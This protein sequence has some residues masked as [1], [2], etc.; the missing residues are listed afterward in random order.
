ME[1]ARKVAGALRG[2]KRKRLASPL[3]SWP[4]PPAPPASALMKTL[5]PFLLASWVCV[6]AIAA[7]KLNVLFIATDDWRPE[8][9]CYGAKGMVTPN[10]DKFAASA[11]RFERAYCQFPLCNPSRTSMLTGRY[12]T[13]TGVLNNDGVFHQMHPDWV[14]LPQHFKD[15]G[16]F[17]A[18]TGKIFHGGLDDKKAW[19]EVRRAVVPAGRGIKPPEGWKPTTP[20]PGA[21]R[22]RQDPR[23]SDR[24]VT[25][26]GDGEDHADY[27]VAKHG[28]ALLEENKD[29]PFFIA[30]GFT[31]PHSPPTAPQRFFDLHDPAKIELPPDFATRPAAP[32]GF[33]KASIPERSGDLFINRD[34]SPD[35]ARRMIQAYRASASWTDWNIGR[36]L[37]A[38]DRLGLA[39]KT[40]VVFFGDHGY[41]LGEKGKWSKHA[42]LYEVGARVPLI[43]RLPK[44]AGN[45]KPSPR[46]VELLDVYPTLAEACALPPP[47]GSEGQSFLPLL[48]DPQAEWKH[49]AFT[50]SSAH[51]FGRAVRTE[52]WRYAEYEGE[53]G[54]A[55][56]FDEQADPHE[57]KNL[58]SDPAHAKI[59]AE[60]K[61]LLQQLPPRR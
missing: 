43:V 19:T 54:G 40:L 32:A 13:T 12:P 45:S 59:V 11:V 41:H 37:D 52:R 39:E 29:K 16:Y 36:V 51:G 35:D 15:N 53:D 26:E 33:P 49:P 56:L 1:V 44:A 20:P 18:A 4:A 14:S 3:G 23:L 48:R 55:M 22:S 60:M 2:V 8:I 38:L 28:I 34:A 27:Y 30:V 10:V 46:T 9:A 21:K 7:E 5:L 50:V 25:M 17:V 24:I 57:M 31:K 6:N 47:A 58:A 61:T 42:S